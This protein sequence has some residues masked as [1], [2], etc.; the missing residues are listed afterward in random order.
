MN[1][2]TAPPTNLPHAKHGSPMPPGSLCWPA[3][4]KVAQLLISTAPLRY[5]LQQPQ[6][7]GAPSPP[8]L[9]GDPMMR[10]ASD[11]QA[12]G[13]AEAGQD[14]STK[15]GSASKGTADNLDR[16][17]HTQLQSQRRT[18]MPMRW[19]YLGRLGKGGELDWGGGDY[20]NVPVPALPELHET[21][22]YM[23]IRGLAREGA[24]EGREV[25][26]G[27]RRSK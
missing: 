21:K 26:W 7:E 10:R 1:P 8:R 25:R 11:V 4:M 27:P 23:I 15:R 24:H 16:T 6:A 20:P 17:H 14:P 13:R 12:L 5:L 22:L 18:G 3:P 9:P 2:G 19:S